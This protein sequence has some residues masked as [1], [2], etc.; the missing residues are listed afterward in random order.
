MNINKIFRDHINGTEGQ[1]KD[2][3]DD[4]LRKSELDELSRTTWLNVPLTRKLKTD[5]ELKQIEYLARASNN[6]R[7][8]GNTQQQTAELI[9]AQT[10]SEILTMIAGETTE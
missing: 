8:V 3:A 7:Y 4:I 2:S 6:A 10:I 1:E 9:A 5:L